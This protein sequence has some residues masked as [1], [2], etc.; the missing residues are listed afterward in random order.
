MKLVYTTKN[1]RMSVELEG[2]SQAD[3]FEQVAQFQEVFENTECVRNGKKSDNVKFVVRE[4]GEEN[5]YYE[6]VCQDSDAELRGARL[7]FGQ[8]KKGGSL[9]P[10][11]KDKEG[12]WLKHNGW[13]I[14]GVDTPKNDKKEDE[15]KTETKK[16]GAPF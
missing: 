4:D 1:G 8:H 5:K 16:E 12:K 11:R 7:A 13:N 9:F 6:L 2:K 14:Y 10:K 3:I 15:S